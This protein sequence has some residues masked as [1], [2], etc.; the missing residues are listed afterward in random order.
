MSSFSY[1][2]ISGPNQSGVP[3]VYFENAIDVLERALGILANEE[4]AAKIL[5]WLQTDNFF[6]RA[7]I[8]TT[9][10]LRELFKELVLQFQE[11]HVPEFYRDSL[12]A[13]STAI[14]VAYAFEAYAQAWD[15]SHSL[16]RSPEQAIQDFGADLDSEVVSLL[17]NYCNE[18]PEMVRNLN[19]QAEDVPSFE[20]DTDHSDLLIGAIESTVDWDAIEVN[21]DVRWTVTD[22]D[23]ESVDESDTDAEDSGLYSAAYEDMSFRETSDNEP[24]WDTG[25]SYQDGDLDEEGEVL[26][27]DEFEVDPLIALQQLLSRDAP[28]FAEEREQLRNALPSLGD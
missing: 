17:S 4:Q 5:E 27:E 13:I 9:D 23:V 3:Q 25:C 1:D 6:E 24:S 19:P 15:L 11:S 20:I 14:T 28:I 10:S 2:P 7:N 26:E 8:N 18:F 12:P 16:L 22:I 21:E